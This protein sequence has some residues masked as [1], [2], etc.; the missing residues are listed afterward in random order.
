MI[1][2]LPI[3]Q[4]PPAG[5][6]FDGKDSQGHDAYRNRRQDA[7]CDGL[8]AFL[9]VEGEQGEKTDVKDGDGQQRP[10]TDSHPGFGQQPAH[11]PHDQHCAEIERDVR[12][13]ETATSCWLLE[14]EVQQGLVLAR[15]ENSCLY[16][17]R[18]VLGV[19]TVRHWRAP[20]CGKCS[21]S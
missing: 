8:L 1:V 2:R 15:L 6:A 10:V 4:W 9:Q 5:Q 16:G 12:Q 18:Q 17:A 13:L 20:R 11:R 19:D 3:I 14:Q 21:W 7:R